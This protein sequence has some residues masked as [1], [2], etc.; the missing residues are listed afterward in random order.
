MVGELILLKQ[1][2]CLNWGQQLGRERICILFQFPSLGQLLHKAHPTP[3]HRVHS[4][5]P[6]ILMGVLLIYLHP[7]VGLL[8]SGNAWRIIQ[9]TLMVFVGLWA[10]IRSKENVQVYLYSQY[11]PQYTSLGNVNL[12]FVNH[13]LETSEIY[14]MTFL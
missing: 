2:T 10:Y 5:L 6:R 12:A 8:C 4:C 9:R 14:G 11:F 7:D 1:I 13:L 3:T